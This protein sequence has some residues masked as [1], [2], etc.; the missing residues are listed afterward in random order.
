MPTTITFSGVPDLPFSSYEDQDFS[1]TSEG[2][3]PDAFLNGQL[4]NPVGDDAYVLVNYSTDRAV[5]QR[6]DGSTFGVTSV[7]LNGFAWDAPG[8]AGTTEVTFFFRGFTAEGV[9]EA[10][11][12]TDDIDGFQSV[13]LANLDARFS[14]G[15]FA[16]QWWAGDGTGWGS[17]D[18]LVLQPNRAPV[19]QDV[20]VHAPVT[21]LL[22]GHLVASD[23]DG[24]AL[25]FEFVGAAPQ[26]VRIDPEGGAFYVTASEADLEL[27]LGQSRVVT[28]QYRATDGDAFSAPKTVTVTLEGQTPL[29]QSI[30]GNQH[31]NSLVG[32]AGGDTLRG[33]QN[34]DTLIGGSGDDRLIGDQDGDVLDGGAGDDTLDGGVG[35]DTLTGGRGD[36]WL[37]GGSS[38]DLFIFDPASGDDVIVDFKSNNDSLQFN[39]AMFGADATFEGIMSHARQVGAN[40]EISYL[41]EDDLT[42]IITLLDVSRASLKAGDFLFG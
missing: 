37:V 17:F 16:F 8:V 22:T 7:D 9:V 42:H 35:R 28:F 26:G 23:V 32:T 33:Y 6:L 3:Y 4:Q 39:A 27:P 11:F 13:S 29:G 38:Q 34:N 2:N 12:R 24:Q 30:E 19:A 36:D 41:G 18:N 5:L 20:A 31:P 10:S 25:R 1:I 15:L 14:S 40:V 21:P